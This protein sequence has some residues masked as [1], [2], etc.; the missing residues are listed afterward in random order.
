M[1]TI[2]EAKYRYISIIIAEK[3]GEYY[4][5]SEKQPSTMWQKVTPTELI[6]NMNFLIEC[7]N[8]CTKYWLSGE[9]HDAMIDPNE[10]AEASSYIVKLFEG[11]IEFIKGHKRATDGPK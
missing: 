11:V 3:D 1:K 8:E 9:F 5:G 4:W 10:W 7:E 2:F 6:D